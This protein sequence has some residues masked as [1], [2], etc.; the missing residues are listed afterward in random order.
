MK[1]DL[2]TSPADPAA[3]VAHIA[4]TPDP[5][6]TTTVFL[7]GDRDDLEGAEAFIVVMADDGAIL[8]QQQTTI[9]G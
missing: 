8:A 5:D 2:R 6:G 1:V 9:G 4:K 7:A 3:S